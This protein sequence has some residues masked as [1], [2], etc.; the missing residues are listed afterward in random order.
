VK[1]SMKRRA[2]RSPL[3]RIAAGGTSI[4]ARTNARGWRN[5]VSEDDRFFG[6]HPASHFVNQMA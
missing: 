5:L 2:V 6:H 3:A 4:P 1:S